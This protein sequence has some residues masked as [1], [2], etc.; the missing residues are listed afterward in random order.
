[1]PALI[2]QVR[3][4]CILLFING[5]IKADA[6]PKAFGMHVVLKRPYVDAWLGHL[7]FFLMD[8]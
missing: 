6:I 1:M 8:V 5:E 2:R 3:Y 7:A 4:S